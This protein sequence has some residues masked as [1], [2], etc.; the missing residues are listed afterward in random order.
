M[1]PRP[2]VLAV[3]RQ[4][5]WPLAR[6]DH[7]RTLQLRAL[8]T[9]HR[10]RL[11]AP[12]C[13]RAATAEQA[14]RDAGIEPLAV[15]AARRRQATEALRVTHATRAAEPYVLYRRQRWSAVRAALRLAVAQVV[16]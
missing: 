2:S 9:A 6:G 10:V 11:I 7:R 16:S 14:L 5:P 4:L 1:T 12:S 15:G 3:T 13:D 8:A